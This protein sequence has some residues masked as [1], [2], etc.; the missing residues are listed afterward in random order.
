MKVFRNIFLVLVALLMVFAF[1]S[2]NNDPKTD[3]TPQS[4]SEIYKLTAT[5]GRADG[6]F[7]CDKF[8]L[9]FSQA[10]D[11][12]DVFF[13]EKDDVFSLKYRS[14]TEFYEFNVRNGA[15]KWVYESKTGLTISEPD[16]AGWITV[17]YT[18]GDNYYD[19]TEVN[20]T[21]GTSFIFDFIGDIIPGD[22][23][24]VKDIT[25]NGEDMDLEV[26]MVA[27]YATPTFEETKDATWNVEE[28][29]AVFYF[30]GDPNPD[31]STFRNPKY[32]LVKK[33]A[34]MTTN[35]E[36]EGFTLK[37]YDAGPDSAYRKFNF[38][39][40]PEESLITKDTPLS[41]N[42]KIALVYTPIAAT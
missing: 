38:T 14:T 7:S 9:D 42:T 12:E 37:M 27:G 41:Y 33:G 28:A 34:S 32:E 19:G 39:T 16:A 5:K 24:E 23:L 29:Y 11:Q 21:A 8:R 36:K 13:V 26:S 22:I 2:C 1:A 30:E 18:F 15:G 25:L 10:T 40:P 4:D 20:Y 3:P 17:S 6:W 35:L 31:G